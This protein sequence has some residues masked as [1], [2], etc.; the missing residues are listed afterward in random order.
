M[1]NEPKSPKVRTISNIADVFAETAFFVNG[2]MEDAQENGWDSVLAFGLRHF[3][4]Q[5][6]IDFINS[7]F[8]VNPLV[9]ANAIDLVRQYQAITFRNF[10][11]LKTKD[12]DDMD[13]AGEELP[14]EV[15]YDPISKQYIVGNSVGIRDVDEAQMNMMAFCLSRLGRITGFAQGYDFSVPGAKYTYQSV[16]PEDV[17]AAMPMAAHTAITSTKT[18]RGE[19]VELDAYTDV[20]F[21]VGILNTP[22]EQLDDVEQAAE[23]EQGKA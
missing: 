8:G 2:S 17:Y 3:S 18:I 16:G 12:I 13:T 21:I 22:G 15:T 9:M 5:D 20:M 4:S 23:D 11:L 14:G 10:Q 1:S 6:Y 7:R 19:E